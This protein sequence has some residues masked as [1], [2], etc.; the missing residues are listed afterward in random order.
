MRCFGGPCD[1]AWVSPS[2]GDRWPAAVV[3]Q[4]GSVLRYDS[5]YGHVLGE[6]VRDAGLYIWQGVQG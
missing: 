4:Y 2:L 5:T 3:V 1:G 6:H